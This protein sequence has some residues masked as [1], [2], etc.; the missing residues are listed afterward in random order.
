MGILVRLFVS[1]GGVGFLPPA[2]GTYG[3]LQGV[4]LFIVV[5][6][7]APSLASL[8]LGAAI[9]LLLLSGV[10][11][12]TRITRTYNHRDPSSIVVDEITGQLVTL[13]GLP[14]SPAAIVSG[15]LLFRLF[16]IWKPFP[17]RQSE[18]LP[19]GWGIFVDDLIAAVYATAA[20]RLLLWLA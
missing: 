16:D 1:G 9:L 14:F 5:N 6:K 2:P 11:F 7:L 10:F 3:A 13:W 20:T 19:G 18:R 12:S 15:F 17:V 8:L 4:L